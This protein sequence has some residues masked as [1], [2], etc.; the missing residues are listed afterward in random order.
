MFLMIALSVWSLAYGMEFISPD[1]F[2][3]LWWVKVEYFGVA[4][5]GLLLFRFVRTMSGQQNSERP[6]EHDSH[7]RYPP[8]INQQQPSSDVAVSLAE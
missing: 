1:L 6:A 8:G 5:I 4:W 7:C 3:K 2:T